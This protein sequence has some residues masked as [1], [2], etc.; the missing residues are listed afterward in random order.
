MSTYHLDFESRD[1]FVGP[2]SPNVVHVGKKDNSNVNPRMLHSHDSYAEIIAVSRGSDN[3]QINGRLYQMTRGNIV[4][5]NPKKLHSERPDGAEP[6]LIY[7]CG[8]SNFQFPDLPKDNLIDNNYSPLVFCPEHDYSIIEQCLGKM[9][10]L[11]SAKDP[12]AKIICNNMITVILALLQKHI[13]KSVPS[14]INA[15]DSSLSF[16]L[17]NYIDN[18][19]MHDISFE[20]IAKE[21]FVTPCHAS[22][23]F[24]KHVGTSPVKY[25]TNRRIGEAQSLLLYTSLSIAEIAERVGYDNPNYFCVVFK[26][27]TGYSPTDYRNRIITL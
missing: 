20:K 15:Q 10:E 22:Y 5:I 3:Y 12:Y 2:N 14:N 4:L 13:T 23:A 9:V 25:L 17:K 8:I 16:E 7:S 24:K 19:F 1:L 6:L 27:T 11:T 21:F 26:K 18:N